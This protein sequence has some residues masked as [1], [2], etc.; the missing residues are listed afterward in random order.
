MASAFAGWNGHEVVHV[1]A[2][3][4]PGEEQAC[5]VFVEQAG[6]LQEALRKKW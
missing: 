3:M 4:V 1:E 2:G 5:A 6:V